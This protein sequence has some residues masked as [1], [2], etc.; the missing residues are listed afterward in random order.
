MLMM[1]AAQHSGVKF[2]DYTKDGR[3]MAEAQLRVWEAYGHDVLL[4]CSDPAREVIDL[5]GDG[6]IDWFEDQGPVINEAR[7]ALADKARLT[8]LKAP[9][10]LDP[11]GRMQDRVEAIKIMRRA[12]GQEVSIAGWVEGPLALAAELRGINT[13][14][15]DM[16]D[17][18]GFVGDLLDFCCEVAM[19]FADA[20]VR[21]GADT[22]GMSDAASWLAEDARRRIRQLVAI[23][24]C[25][26]ASWGACCS[27]DCS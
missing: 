22:I 21:A 24:A 8:S 6:S 27:A 23:T 5:C 12:V 20:Q 7:A 11:N 25:V 2:I 18:P 3:I 14:M 13:L 19:V 4:T 10:H 1:F 16:M 9:M 26:V 15:F 17:D